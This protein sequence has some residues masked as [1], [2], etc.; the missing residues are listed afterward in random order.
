MKIQ[1]FGKANWVHISCGMLHI[2]ENIETTSFETYPPL[3]HPG[4]IS[5]LVNTSQGV[6]MYTPKRSEILCTLV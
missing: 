4:R 3:S 1:L 5:K 6:K 2:S